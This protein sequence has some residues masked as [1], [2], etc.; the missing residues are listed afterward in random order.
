M[1]E[2]DQGLRKPSSQ[3]LSAQ[4]ST[5]AQKQKQYK[6]SLIYTEVLDEEVGLQALR[7]V[8]WNPFSLWAL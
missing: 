5:S 3:N 2:I 4:I 6:D 7:L 1:L 8:K